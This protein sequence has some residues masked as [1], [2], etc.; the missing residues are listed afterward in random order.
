LSESPIYYLSLLFKS[1]DALLSRCLCISIF[2]PSGTIGVTLKL[3]CLFMNAYANNF[4]LI[5]DDQRRFRVILAYGM[6]L[7]H[8]DRGKSG[9]VPTRQDLK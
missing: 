1:Q 7:S 4:G 6:S 8:S 3:N 5:F 9:S 2:V